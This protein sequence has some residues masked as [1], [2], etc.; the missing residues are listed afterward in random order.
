MRNVITAISVQFDVLE[1]VLS[2]MDPDN[3]EVITAEMK[4][5]VAELEALDSRAGEMLEDLLSAQIRYPGQGAIYWALLESLF[6]LC[7]IGLE[8]N[9]KDRV[10]DQQLEQLATLTPYDFRLEG[11]ILPEPAG[12]TQ[13]Y[14]CRPEN[15]EALT[16]EVR[17]GINDPLARDTLIRWANFCMAYSWGLVLYVSPA[18]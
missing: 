13:V 11:V 4:G 7:G 3:R 18:G 8:L 14:I 15:L 1:S 2:D 17:A 9:D 12:A 6:P 16:V 5:R 10:T